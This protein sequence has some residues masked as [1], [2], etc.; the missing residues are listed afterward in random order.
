MDTTERNFEST[1]E[2][3]LLGNG[4]TST[5]DLVA[6][7]RVPYGPTAGYVER[8]PKKHYD[9]G[10]CL[11]H[12]A[13]LGFIY[14]TQPEQWEKLKVQHGDGVKDRFL[15]RLVKEI[16]ARGTLD[17]LRR[18]VTDLGSRFDLA[19]FRPETGLNEEHKRLYNANTLSVMRQVHYSQKNE[20]SL[21]LVL[22]LNGLPI[23]TAELKNPLTNQTVQD[24]VGQYRRDRD[25]KEPLLSFG[26]CLAHF[27]VDP[28]LVYVATHLQGRKT[29][30]LPF[31]RGD[32]NGAVQLR[33]LQEDRRGPGVRR[34]VQ[35]VR[36]Q[37]GGEPAQPEDRV[38]GPGERK[39]P[40]GPQ[41]GPT[42]EDR[43]TEEEQGVEVLETL[44]YVA[45]I[46]GGIG[47]LVAATLLVHRSQLNFDVI[48]NC[49]QRF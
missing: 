2:A 19:Y 7:E 22:L 8:D 34:S 27:A 16:E 26:R 14:A 46:A 25:P 41:R 23:I 48:M 29:R 49:N 44:A 21:D 47:I 30:F 17:V 5:A 1:I 18:G 38:A 12:E 31:N 6:D 15:R 9:R 11:D 32:N 28:D 20:N 33:P 10:L 35:G 45:Q 37:E 24:A 40:S 39:D 4:A 43:P 3:Y 42:T 36:L 13:L